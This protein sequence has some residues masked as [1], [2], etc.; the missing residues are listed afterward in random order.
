MATSTVASL[1]AP[2]IARDQ[3]R[4]SPCDREASPRKRPS[5]TANTGVTEWIA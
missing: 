1:L 3:I 5:G 4:M 2:S